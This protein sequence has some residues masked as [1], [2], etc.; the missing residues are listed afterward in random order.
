MKYKSMHH[1]IPLSI[2]VDLFAMKIFYVL[3]HNCKYFIYFSTFYL[4]N[5]CDADKPGAA[6][7]F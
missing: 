5:C 4:L 3:K 2:L 1:R 6:I 7:Y